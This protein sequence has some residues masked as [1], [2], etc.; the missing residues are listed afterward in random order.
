M[1]TPKKQ[2]DLTSLDI[3]VSPL[4]VVSVFDDA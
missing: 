2:I 3:F 4:A 1:K